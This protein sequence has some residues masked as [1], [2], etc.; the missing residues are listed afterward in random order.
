[1]RPPSDGD[2]APLGGQARVMP[3]FLGS[4]AA[5]ALANMVQLVR[6][7]KYYAPDEDLRDPREK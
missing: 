4:S 2:L 7:E 3:F 6:T 5:F 1:M